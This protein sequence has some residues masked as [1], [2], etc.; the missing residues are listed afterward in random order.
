[1]IQLIDVV[2]KDIHIVFEMKLSDV[3]KLKKALELAV[4]DFDGTKEEEK[5]AADYLQ[6]HFYPS[7]MEVLNQ[8]RNSGDGRDT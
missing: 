5:E 6:D 1:M 4:V 2:P 7:L 8:I 3:F